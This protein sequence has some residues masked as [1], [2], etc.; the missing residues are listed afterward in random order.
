LHIAYAM[1]HWIAFTGSVWCRPVLAALMPELS[2][3]RIFKAT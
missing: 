3:Q 1:P 2:R